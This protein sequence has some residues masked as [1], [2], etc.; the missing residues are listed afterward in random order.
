MKEYDQV[1][2]YLSN[3]LN[4][5]RRHT[6]KFE[7]YHIP[8]SE[9]SFR[10]LSSIYTS[11]KCG[12][13]FCRSIFPPEEITDFIDG[14]ETCICPHCGIDA[15]IGDST[16]IPIRR[17]VLEELHDKWFGIPEKT[18]PTIIVAD[19]CNN[20]LKYCSFDTTTEAELTKGASGIIPNLYCFADTN[21]EHRQ[22]AAELKSKGTVIVWWMTS[23]SSNDN[24]ACASL[25]DIIFCTGGDPTEIS[26]LKEGQNSLFVRT[27]G[28]HGI[29]YRFCDK[30]WKTLS[31]GPKIT[32]DFDKA[33]DFIASITIDSILRAEK[34]PA[35]LEEEDIEKIL[36][37]CVRFTIEA[38]LQGN[39]RC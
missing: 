28:K 36:Y 3:G 23:P 33:T 5:E 16:G 39:F 37:D 20:L 31:P 21:S 24:A 32:I 6:P 19:S 14:G 35:E 29:L 38:Y 30:A 9:A 2:V 18:Q 8:A 10:N 7:R 11:K 1:E 26:F 27:I 4:M 15:V 25:A 17:D 22:R 12:C 34:A 13:Y